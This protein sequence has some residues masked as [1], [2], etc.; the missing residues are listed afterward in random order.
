M[1]QCE[2]NLDPLT[3]P[4]A[5]G[6]DTSIG[7]LHHPDA[8]ERL[9][10][11]ALGPFA[12]VAVEKEHSLGKLQTG[13]IFV[14][15]IDL[16]AVSDPAVQ[17]RV[18]PHRFAKNSDTSLAGLNEAANYIHHNVD[19]PEP[20]GPSRPVMPGRI[21]TLTLLMPSISRRTSARGFRCAPWGSV[22]EWR[23]SSIPRG[24]VE[25][26]FHYA[27]AEEAIGDDASSGEAHTDVFS[28]LD[29]KE[30]ASEPERGIDG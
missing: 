30:I 16:G 12:A 6:A 26:P 19:L 11:H 25:A 4:F 10:C 21:S 23:S 15:V 18:V 2:G 29:P 5:V 9:A 24:T 1:D 17:F 14:E 13:E 7:V 8:F 28:L 20:L 3:H 27:D 22:E